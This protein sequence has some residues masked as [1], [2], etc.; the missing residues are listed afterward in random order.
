[1][2]VVRANAE[3]C[4]V[5]SRRAEVSFASGAAVRGLVEHPGD[6]LST[7]LGA[8]PV[9]AVFGI[10]GILVANATR[11]ADRGS[12]IRIEIDA[13]KGGEVRLAV[14]HPG[15]TIEPAQ[16]PRLPAPGVSAQPSAM[17]PSLS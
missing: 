14:A 12:M 3:G 16:L 6:H 1:M 17:A 4:R 8:L 15:A 11:Y 7:R 10:P 9:V 5:L 2:L 13:M